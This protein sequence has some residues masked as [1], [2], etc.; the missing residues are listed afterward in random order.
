MSTTENKNIYKVWQGM[1]RRGQA[2]RRDAR[3]G[4]FGG[5]D[6]VWRPLAE[7]GGFALGNDKRLAR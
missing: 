2:W 5:K 6:I 1:I 7:A 3:Q 4:V